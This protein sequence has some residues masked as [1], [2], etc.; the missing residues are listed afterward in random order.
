MIK[1]INKRVKFKRT[2]YFS[3]YLHYIMHTIQYLKLLY[4]SCSRY[5]Y[6]CTLCL[7]G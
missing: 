1:H 5:V 2:E 3:K 4:K 6:K 7:V